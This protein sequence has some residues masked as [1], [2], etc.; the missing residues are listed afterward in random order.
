MRK[1][2]LGVLFLLFVSG[3]LTSA[4]TD[5]RVVSSQVLTVCPSD[6]NFTTIQAAID[7]ARAGDTIEVQ[8]GTYQENVTIRNKQDLVLQGTGPDQTILDGRAAQQQEITPGILV[9]NSR[10]V[11]IQGFTVTNSRRGL[12]AE[13]VIGLV[14][15]DN[16]FEDNLRAAIT[17]GVG[18][19]RVEQARLINNIVRNTQADRD[20]AFGFGVDIFGSQARLEGN[21]IE[22]SADCGL[23]VTHSG[24]RPGQAT[25][26]NNI[27]RNNRGGNLCGTVPLTLLSN[28]PPEGTLDTVAVPQDVPT[29][30]E[31]INQV[32]PGGTITVAAGTYRGQLQIYKSVTIRGAGSG[33]TI[34]QAPGTDWT[35]VNIA[36]DQLNVVLEGLTVTGGRRGVQIDTGPNGNITLKEVKVDRNG[37]GGR[38][39]VGI[40]VFGQGTVTLEQVSISGNRGQGIGVFGRPHV[41]VRNT[42]IAQNAQHGIFTIGRPTMVIESSTIR[43][44]ELRGIG[45]FN[46]TQATIH[47]S[48]IENNGGFSGIVLANNSQ[49]TI[50]GSTISRNVEAGIFV[51][52]NAQA[53]IRDNQ[54]TD[55][56]TNAQGFFGWGIALR[57]GAQVTIEGNA[58]SGHPLSGIA[59]GAP[60][61]NGEAVRAEI[62]NNCIQNNQECGV[63]ADR[64]PEIEIT[65]QGNTIFGNRLGSICGDLSKF[66]P[67]F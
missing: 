40:L 61:L 59:V 56:R 54:I 16:L 31:A 50:E 13:N 48:T 1:S 64:D 7:A 6:C 30:Q 42:T 43:G 66:P 19:K 37:A 34:L 18:A 14:I 8:A 28:P 29:L 3:G 65:G 11:T 33:R 51:G 57:A 15:T 39:D 17:I 4:G 53:E 55:N 46:D 20:G 2:L 23:R 5:L 24:E 12:Q 67:G 35:V 27:I 44:N 47:R 41:T 32:R 26:S 21:T 10:N 45:L 49:V 36:T 52:W 60:N 9:L 22:G 25:G 62:S 58:I 38:T 63:W